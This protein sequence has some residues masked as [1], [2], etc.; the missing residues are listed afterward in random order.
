M[1][2]SIKE[3]T[4]RSSEKER[5]KEFKRRRKRKTK[6]KE[7]KKKYIS[8]KQAKGLNKNMGQRREREGNERGGREEKG[9]SEM[10]MDYP[11][12]LKRVGQD[13]REGETTENEVLV[14]LRK[15]YAPSHPLSSLYLFTSSCLLRRVVKSHLKKVTYL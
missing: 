1:G 3:K 14:A 15:T 10:Y 8:K 13:E 5:K 4:K 6:G 9:V 7:E 2:K 11:S 12:P